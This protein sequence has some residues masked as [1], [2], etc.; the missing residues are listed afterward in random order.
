MGSPVPVRHST[1]LSQQENGIIRS[2][3][4]RIGLLSALATGAVAA[5]R[6]LQRA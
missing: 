2:D 5:C 6:R 4:I 3:A 1:G